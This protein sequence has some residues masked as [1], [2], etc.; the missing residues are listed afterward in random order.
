[1]PASSFLVKHKIR[2]LCAF[3]GVLLQKNNKIITNVGMNGI[4]EIILAIVGGGG[5]TIGVQR[6]YLL[7]TEKRKGEAEA[8]SI[9]IAN[10]D[11]RIESYRETVDDLNNRLKEALE[12]MRQLEDALYKSNAQVIELKNELLQ[13][14]SIIKNQQIEIENLKREN[15]ELQAKLGE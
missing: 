11:K 9:E 15:A 14:H 7:R 5:L 13:A 1:M 8:E 4:L 6:L 3:N 10:E 12:K 2:Y